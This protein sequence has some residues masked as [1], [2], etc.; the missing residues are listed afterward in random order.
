MTMPENDDELMARLARA[1]E[2]HD[3][4]PDDVIA[5]AKAAF[6]ARNLDEELAELLYDSAIDR[7]PVLTRG[8]TLRT[9]SFATS[10]LGIELEVDERER[11]IMGQLVPA[12]G[13]N[14]ELEVD[15]LVVGTGEIDDL[16]RF[17]FD[18][19]PGAGAVSIVCWAGTGDRRICV[20]RFD[21]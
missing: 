14:V 10:D 19:V 8:E 20:V 11:R 6:I 21:L 16:G 18:D 17:R 1:V 9:L 3:P 5:G 13:V 7:E 15:G 2:T 4:V 12:Q